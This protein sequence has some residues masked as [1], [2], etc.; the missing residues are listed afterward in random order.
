MRGKWKRCAGL[1]R[2]VTANV[3]I[4]PVADGLAR[5]LGRFSSLMVLCARN[6]FSSLR[7]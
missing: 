4:V 3:A 1:R 5:A 6:K 7:L 2:A